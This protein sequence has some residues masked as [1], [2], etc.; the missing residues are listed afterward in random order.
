MFV[1]DGQGDV[2]EQGG[3][4]PA[5]WGTGVRLPKL[6]IL[7]EDVGLQERLHQVQHA[8]VSDPGPHPVHEADMRDL[9]EARFDV[10]LDHHS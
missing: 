9:V 5:L 7:T 8:L 1:Q 3:E 4:D 6:S 2:G 10:T